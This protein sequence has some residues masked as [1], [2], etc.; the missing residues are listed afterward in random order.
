MSHQKGFTLVELLVVIAIIGILISLL[1]PAFIAVRNA[2]RSTQC[3][4]NLRSIAL[5]LLART[6][7]DP[8]GA[9][10]TGAFDN[11][12]DGSVELYGWVADCVAQEILPAQLLCPS[13]L[14]KTSEKINDNVAGFT[15][16]NPTSSSKGPPARRG[17]GLYYQ[18][19]LTGSEIATLLFD[20]GINTNYASGWFLVR[21]KPIVVDGS[22]LGSLKEWWSG[23][24]TSAVQHCVG[25]LRISLLDR[26]TIPA[27]SIAILG[28]AGVGDRADVSGVLD[29]GGDGYLQI[30]IPAPYNLA[31]GDGACESSND[32]PSYVDGNTGEI[33]YANGPQSRQYLERWAQLVEG[34]L[35]LC[36]QST[37]NRQDTRDFFAWHAKTMNIAFADGSIR[38]FVDENGDGYINPGFDPTVRGSQNPT[39]LDHGYLSGEVEINGF[40][41]F[42]GTFFDTFS[43]DAG[44]PSFQSSPCL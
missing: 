35:G 43:T 14:C 38:N 24:S 21:S 42:T 19:P 37:D 32:G 16:P 27:S 30:N 28:D 29:T 3:K 13:S 23:A 17:S 12:R 20:E 6:A 40:E 22:T 4:S 10:C 41:W 2:A 44:G 5:G 31:E 15:G 8:A 33:R 39:T 11:A 1:F 34:D 36:G 26:G 18:G 7:N 25:P 9:Y